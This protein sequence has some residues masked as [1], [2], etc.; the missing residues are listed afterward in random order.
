MLKR[1]L[2]L[3]CTV[4]AVLSLAPLQA[5]AGTIV[6][7]MTADGRTASAE[8]IADGSNVIEGTTVQFRA[9]AIDDIRVVTVDLFV[10][11]E[12]R[13]TRSVPPYAFTLVVPEFDTVT[14]PI[15]V[16]LTVE[17]VLDDAHLAERDVWQQVTHVDGQSVRSPRPAWWF[18]DDP[19]PDLEL[20]PVEVAG[21]DN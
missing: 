7:F 1:I 15:G 21:S 14:G 9:T 20:T 3:A 17:E 5:V 6:D 18:H 12:R 10:D 2:R 8:F 13:Q 11:G 4:G 19:Q 16:V